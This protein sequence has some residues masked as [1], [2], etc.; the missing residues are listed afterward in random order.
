M[1]KVN[2]T[3]Q[4]IIDLPLYVHN[5]KTDMIL[6]KEIDRNNVENLIKERKTEFKA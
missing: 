1:P 5:K 3:S 2:I 4:T 6:G